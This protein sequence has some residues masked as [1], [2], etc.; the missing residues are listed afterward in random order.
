MDFVGRPLAGT[1]LRNAHINSINDCSSV[2][3]A[4]AYASSD[5]LGW[6]KEC[7]MKDKPIEFFGRYDGSCAVDPAILKWF[8]DCKSP[9]V[10]YRIVPKWL[11]AKVIWWVDQGAYIGS[12]NLTQRAWNNNYEAGMFLSDAELEHYGLVGQLNAF[13][14]GLRQNSQPLRDD[15]YIAQRDLDRERAAM[16]A[17]FRRLQKKF[18]DNDPTVRATDNPIA[19]KPTRSVDTR[20]LAFASEWNATLQDMLNIADRVSLPENRPLW[21]PDTI[22]KGVQADQFLHAFYYQVVRADHLEKDSYERF[23]EK[24]QKNP[25]AAL[26]DALKWWRKSDFDFS[27]ELQTMT[28]WAPAIERAFSKQRVLSLTEQ[29]WV[30]TISKVHAFGEHAAHITN[31]MLG[32]PPE[33]QSRDAHTIALAHWLWNFRTEGGKTPLEVINYVV[34]GPGDTI[35]R[36]WNACHD[37]EWQLRTY[38]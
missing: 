16:M 14:D 28:V 6:L 21:V 29:E 1:L 26:V 9:N 17:E 2:I 38:P 31:K 13:F 3:A 23:F 7:N 27:Q 30:D 36:I 4:I 24:N 35:Q 37:P 5:S 22:P 33:Q 8:L 11:H 34:W 32:L 10:N 15:H 25:E 12:A 20:Y 19:A 18:D